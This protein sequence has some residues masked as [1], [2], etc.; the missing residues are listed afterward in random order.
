MMLMVIPVVD[1]K[2]IDVKRLSGMLTAATIVDRRFS[3][4]R[5]MT[6]TANPAPSP[7]SR[8]SESIESVM[9]IDESVTTE[10]STISGCALTNVSIAAMESRAVVTVFAA[11]DLPTLIER[12]GAPFVSDQPVVW[13]W[14]SETLATSRRRMTYGTPRGLAPPPTIWLRSCAIEV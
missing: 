11:A 9:K 4:K 12:P 14:A 1:I 10:L 3:K 6:R 7:P 5:K 13:T 2:M 8:M